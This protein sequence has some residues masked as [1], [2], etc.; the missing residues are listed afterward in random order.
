[1]R[2]IGGT[3]RIP[4]MRDVSRN[5]GTRGKKRGGGDNNYKPSKLSSRASRE[6]GEGTS[7][8]SGT[9]RGKK[10]GGGKLGKASKQYRALAE[11]S[12]EDDDE[13]VNMSNTE[14]LAI[15]GDYGEDLL[16]ARERAEGATAKLSKN[17]VRKTLKG[18]PKIK[19]RT[20]FKRDGKGRSTGGNKNLRSR[21]EKDR[22]GDE[23][24]EDKNKGK[25]KI[26]SETFQ[27]TVDNVLRNMRET[28]ER[29]AVWIPSTRSGK[30][31]LPPSPKKKK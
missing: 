28:A 13:D 16:T 1:L 19:N 3:S 11:T 15:D 17:D 4:E 10:R 27:R 2:L 22:D 5:T 12:D 7:G 31:R 25:K 23:V 26:S 18:N 14:P 6:L 29:E 21:S 30:R 20:K 24:M 8:T 9:S